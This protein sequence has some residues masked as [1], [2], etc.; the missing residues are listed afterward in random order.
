MGKD[1]LPIVQ[2][3]ADT[4]HHADHP[5]VKHWGCLDPCDVCPAD[6]RKGCTN[7]GER[8]RRVSAVD[9]LVCGAAAVEGQSHAAPAVEELP[10]P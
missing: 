4:E 5:G 3:V 2:V 9:G 8:V 1:V 6:S 10:P 7:T